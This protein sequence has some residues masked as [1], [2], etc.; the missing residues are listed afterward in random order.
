MERSVS[1][2]VKW[3]QTDALEMVHDVLPRDPGSVVLEP[4]E[5]IARYEADASVPGGLKRRWEIYKQSG[6]KFKDFVK[7]VDK[8][9]RRLRQR[10]GE[11]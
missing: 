6:G 10:R 2:A 4:D 5:E 3:A 7:A 9:E 8:L 11:Q 1:D